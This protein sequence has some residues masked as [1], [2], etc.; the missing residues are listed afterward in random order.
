M[1]DGREILVFVADTLCDEARGGYIA[2]AGLYCD[3]LTQQEHIITNIVGVILKQLVGTG[4]IP[5]GVR[6]AFERGKWSLVV[7]GHFSWIGCECLGSLLPR[8][9]ES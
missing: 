6:E 3:F 4:D 1:V 7:E 9:P 5:K 2:V 8:Y